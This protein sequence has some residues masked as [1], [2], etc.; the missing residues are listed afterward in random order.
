[1]ATKA[2]LVELAQEALAGGEVVAE[3]R[4]KYHEAVVS[5]F[6]GMAYTDIIQT[7]FNNAGS[8]YSVFDNLAKRYY[9]KVEESTITGKRFYKI[10]VPL[11][12]LTPKHACIRSVSLQYG[13]QRAFAPISNTSAPIWGELEAMRVD[14]TCAYMIEENEI[15]FELNPPPVGADLL[16]KII[17]SFENYDDDDTV[18]V[19]GGQNTALFTQMYQIMSLRGN[20]DLQIN[21]NNSTQKLPNG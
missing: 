16:V 15:I 4:G 1:M 8:D 21:D 19:P 5:L 3:L 6:L 7:G 11:I 9:G 17:P 12:P 13:Q 20:R 2:Q 18:V 10:P 14:S